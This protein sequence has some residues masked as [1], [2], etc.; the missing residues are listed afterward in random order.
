MLKRLIAAFLAAAGLSVPAAAQD[1]D[2]VT[3]RN[4]NPVVGEVKS[5][6][7][8]TLNFDTEEMDVVPIDWEDIASVTSPLFFEIDTSDGRQF[9]GSLAAGASPGLLVIVGDQRTDTL[10]FPQIVEIGPIESGFFARTNG[11]V[12]FGTNIAK[13]NSLRSIQ[14][15]GRFAYRGPKWGFSVDGDT[16]YQSQESTDDEGNTIETET[17]RNSL[18]GTLNRFFGAR[19]VASASGRAE[20][21]DEL[22]LDNRFLGILGGQY[23]IVRNQGIEFSAG[24]GFAYNDEQFVDTD[25]QTSGE[26]LVTGTFDV[27]DVG[28]IDVFAGL[29]T[30]TNLRESRYR[31]NFDGRV[32]W[33][34]FDDFYLGFTATNRFDSKPPSETAEK[35]DFQYGVTIGWSWS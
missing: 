24:A 34:I 6:K 32:S 3:L 10:P 28:D 23:L 18:Q 5:L 31:V 19:W 15:K 29:D 2:L 9:Y 14:L 8:G 33:E 21:N 4:G 1:S 27:F 20:S 7:R 12:D 25:R 16:Y 11:F 35:N 17:N 26:V 13:A 22:N 30:Y